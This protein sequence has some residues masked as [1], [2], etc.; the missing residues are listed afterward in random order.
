[1]LNKQKKILLTGASGFLGSYIYNYLNS[2]YKVIT[3]GR[4]KSS[5][6]PCNISI[7]SVVLNDNYEIVVHVAG[8]AHSIPKSEQEKKEFYDVNYTGTLNLCKSLENKPPYT[9][10]F[11]STIAVYGIEEGLGIPES[12]P[13]LGNTPY[14]KS[15]ILA[16]EFLQK[17]CKEN[18]VELVVLRLPLIAGI[19]PKGNLGAMINGIKK[20]YYFNISGNRAKKSIVLADDIAK[21]IPDLYG[22]SGIYNL[23]G[24][25]DYTFKQISEIIGKELGK[26]RIL[27]LPY[28]FVKMSS[29]FGNF[30]PYFPINSDKF[31]KMTINLTVSSNKAKEELSWSPKPL[32]DNFKI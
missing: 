1:M 6:V 28:F 20:G 11:I 4:N 8:K 31:K 7:D 13:L 14:A 10:V 19:N 23:S 30:I 12:Y 24:D 29:Y 27:T 18:E 2:E 21:L 16:E 26:K 17:W 9:F 15:K 5:S 3:L 22:K 32:T 25:S